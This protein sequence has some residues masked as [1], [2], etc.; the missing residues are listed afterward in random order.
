MCKGNLADHPQRWNCYGDKSEG[1]LGM[2]EKGQVPIPHDEAEGVCFNI[3]Y[4]NTEIIKSRVLWVQWEEI[5]CACICGQVTLLSFGEII[6]NQ[7]LATLFLL[8]DTNSL[9]AL[10]MFKNGRWLIKG[11]PQ[12]DLAEQTTLLLFIW[13][14]SCLEAKHGMAGQS[15]LTATAGSAY[16]VKKTVAKL[17]HSS[18]KLWAFRNTEKT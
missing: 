4:E 12:K 6:R 17:C 1:T 8:N 11:T 16:S 13:K 14:M 9:I 5:H 10:K 2:V 3:K 15:F 18:Y 7:F